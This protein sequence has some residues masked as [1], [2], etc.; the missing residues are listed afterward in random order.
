MINLIL[1][2]TG[3]L[4]HVLFRE[5]EESG[6][7]VFGTVRDDRTT[8]S[9]F[10]PD[11]QNRL[12]NAVDACDFLSV[13]K[14]IDSINPDVII[15]CIGL[16]RQRPEGQEPLPCI[17]INA[18]F[19][20]LL[21]T[22]CRERNIRLIHYSTD[23][24]FDGKKGI[25]YTEDDPPTARDIYGLTK[26]L[27]ELREAP[28]LTLRT[29]LIGPEIRGHR[30][31]LEWFLAQEGHVNGYTHAI[32]SGLPTCEHARIIREYIL[33]NAH[34]NGLYHVAAQAISKCDLLR[35]IA[36]EYCKKIDIVPDD[37]VREDKWLNADAFAAV[38]G[39][40]PPPWSELV[41]NMRESEI[42][43]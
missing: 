25:P 28:A 14:A 1:G 8:E 15:N 6:F 17:E 9:F 21:F 4:G 7:N 18:R 5:L 30:G 37:S 35:L 38:A 32:F 40:R 2:V 27:G 43:K 39:Y 42:T 33:P 23:C 10:F 26:Y 20:H 13:T 24:V 3:M 34:L 16:I 29:S 41:K 22:L 36:G 12:L 19:P 31:L 11:K